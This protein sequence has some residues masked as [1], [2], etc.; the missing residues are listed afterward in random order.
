MALRQTV[1]VV[2]A[3][4]LVG[5]TSVSASPA[6]AAAGG[7]TP[8]G[9]HVLVGEYSG[10]N[11]PA[12]IDS[13]TALAGSR[14]DLVEWFQSWDEPLYWSSQ[15]AGIDARDVTP[16]ITWSPGSDFSMKSLL[17]GKYDSYLIA[18]AA[19]AKAWT[20]P[21][22]VRP[23]HEMNGNW[24]SYGYGKDSAADFV[25]GWR[26]VVDIFRGHGATN[27]SWV[28]SPNIFGWANTVSPD[29]Y[30]PGDTF[31]DWVGL[32]GYN[33]TG[34]WRS[35]S[36]LF[37]RAYAD[38]TKL[39]AKPLMIAEWGCTEVGGNKAAWIRDAFAQL[40]T[41]MPRIRAMVSF[42]RVA[43]NDFRIDSSSTALIAYQGTV[44]NLKR[45]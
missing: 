30:F 17:G 37:T 23:F 9:G 11:L 39:T 31:V 43:E 14:P 13:Y 15:R 42:D 25:A 4:L 40:P 20:K 16:L 21:I 26:H 44:A 35:F 5:V 29:V 19:S 1:W 3:A 33:Y 36:T 38:V 7:A 22:M 41:A 45:T 28:W 10:Y 12:N 6:G 34:A 27:V 24:N 18:Q 32:D 2:A 8:A